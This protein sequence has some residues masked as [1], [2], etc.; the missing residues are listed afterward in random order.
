M[1]AGGTGAV[2]YKAGLLPTVAMSSTE[3]ECMETAVMG[4]MYL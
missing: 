2:G 1:V 4:R 3:A